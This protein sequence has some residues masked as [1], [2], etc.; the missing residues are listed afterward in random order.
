VPPPPVLGV[1]PPVL[2]GVNVPTLKVPP[3]PNRLEV[4]LVLEEGTDSDGSARTTT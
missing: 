3:P 2:P 1:P 4:E